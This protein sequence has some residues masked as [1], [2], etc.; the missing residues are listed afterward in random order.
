MN[1]IKPG[2]QAITMPDGRWPSLREEFCGRQVSVSTIIA[3]QSL[4]QR[5][6]SAGDPLV[7]MIDFHDG[8]NLQTARLTELAPI[9]RDPDAALFD[10]LARLA[11]QIVVM[12]LAFPQG[13]E[14]IS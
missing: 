6:V 4:L 11:D 1:E 3:P 14:K 12:D 9:G 8:E 13:V 10:E 2:A 5:A 7:A